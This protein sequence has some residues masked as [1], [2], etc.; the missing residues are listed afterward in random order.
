MSIVYSSDLIDIIDCHSSF[1]M[2]PWYTLKGNDFSLDQPY[3]R[4]PT[5]EVNN[6][7]DNKESPP[8]KK[9]RRINKTDV[10]T[11]EIHS[12]LKPFLIKVLD[13]LSK[14]LIEQPGMLLKSISIEKEKSNNEEKDI[15]QFPDWI[16][17]AL[18]ARRFQI[19]ENHVNPLDKDTEFDVL[20]IFY[21]MIQNDSTVCRKIKLNN[22]NYII[23][24]NSAFFM[25]DLENINDLLLYDMNK[26]CYDLVVIDPPWPNK[27]VHRSLKYDTQDIYEFYKIPLPAFIHDQ[28]LVAIWVTNKPKFKKFIIDKLF[29]SWNMIVVAEWLWI[30]VTN[31]GESVIPIDSTHRKTYEQLIIGKLQPND[32]TKSSLSSS[33]PYHHAIISV[34]SK[35]H[36]RKPPL[37]D[38]LSP[39]IRSDA[40]YL[41]LFARCMLP[42]WVSWGSEVLKFQHES[43]FSE[44][45]R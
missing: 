35:Q 29:K 2:L 44:N 14:A 45:K 20:N 7:Q 37:Q 43:Y 4:Q 3:F 28:S 26:N 21:Q 25:G 15:I 27:S 1:G 5:F 17:M 38:V 6:K 11:E 16:S 13:Q 12:H 34:P 23:P 31:H 42:N 18:A 40:K 22:A 36:S 41:E 32:N 24:P 9:K 39:Y 10:L 19:I 8:Q 30:K 33:L